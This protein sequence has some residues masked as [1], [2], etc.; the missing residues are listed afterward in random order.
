MTEASAFFAPGEGRTY[1]LGAARV[2]F[3]PQHGGD[4]SISESITPAHSGAGLHRHDYDEWHIVLEGRYEGQVGDAIRTL[5]VGD[6]MFAPRGTIHGLR[7]LDA[8]PARQMG[9]SSPAGRFEAFVAEVAAAHVDS[10]GPGRAGA[11]DFR[12][13]AARHGIDFIAATTT[14]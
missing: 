1:V 9:I 8:T 11:P 12:A 2:T 13:I 6:M 14:T 7:N 10:G 4:F 5:T 3:K